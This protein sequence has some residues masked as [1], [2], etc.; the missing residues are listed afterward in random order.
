MTD[1]NNSIGHEKI[2]KVP[3]LNF[4]GTQQFLNNLEPSISE[5]LQYVLCLDSLASLNEKDLFLH[6]SRF[7]KEFEET[8]NKLYKYFNLTAQKMN[9]TLN[10][11]KKK[12]FLNNKVVPWE[13]E[14]FSKK[15]I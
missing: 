2:G 7:P 5:N 8:T 15:K 11:N 10:Y 9:I 3:G 6:L 12:V 4:E 14:Q 13:H 1:Y